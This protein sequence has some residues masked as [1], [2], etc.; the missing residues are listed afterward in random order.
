MSR[1]SLAGAAVHAD[2]GR[3]P[4]LRALVRRALVRERPTVRH[5]CLNRAFTTAAPATER[6][7]AV[8]AM[9]GIGLDAQRRFAV[10]EDVRLSIAPGQVIS[11][12]GQ[13]GS[14]KSVLLRAIAEELRRSDTRPFTLD[15]G[16]IA[17]PTEKALVDC[18]AAPLAETLRLLSLAGLNDAFLFLR[19]PEA[20][21]DG[22]RYRLRLALALASGAQ[23]VLIDEFCSMLDRTTARVIAHQVRRFATRT[24]TTFIVATAHD[25]LYDDLLPDVYVEKRFGPG[26]AVEAAPAAT[27]PRRPAC[28]VLRDVRIE[29]AD[30]SA[31]EALRAFHYRGHALP[32]YSHVFAATAPTPC[33]LGPARRVIGVIVYG[34]PSLANRQRNDATGGRYRGRHRRALTRLLNREV[35]T[36]SRVVI[37]P[38]YRGLSLAVR[39]VRETMPLVGTPYVE[40]LATM[41][42][43]NPFFERAGMVRYA[44]PWPGRAARLIAALE[45]ARIPSAVAAVPALLAERLAALDA[46]RRALLWREL[47]TWHRRYQGGRGLGYRQSDD[48]AVL[49]AVAQHL[50][51][52]PVYYLWRNDGHP[53]G[54]IGAASEESESDVGGDVG[55]VAGAHSADRAL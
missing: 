30:R 47:R 9:F 55:E 1:L 32:P 39:L 17:L 50:F 7:A 40:A 31:W 26:A 15:L 43:V 2:D 12:T 4:A 51:G 14:G 16:E 41:G 45:H 42:Q 10:L 44:A 48:D 38:M 23:V 3:V 11:I 29:P 27:R 28:T 54:P 53:A 6:V 52:H 22:Q 37:D 19:R 13:S 8:A 35:R 21:S 49:R 34:L 46:P 18:F 20:L 36:I 33:R 24:G 25:D 5:L